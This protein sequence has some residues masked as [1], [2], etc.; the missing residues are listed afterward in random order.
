LGEKVANYYINFEFTDGIFAYTEILVSTGMVFEG[1][2]IHAG[3]GIYRAAL[4]DGKEA[5]GIEYV[6]SDGVH[7]DIKREEIC[8]YTEQYLTHG[9]YDEHRHFYDCLKKGVNPNSGA[10][11]ALQSVRVCEALKNREGFVV[12]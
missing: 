3:E 10:D 2:E 8:P 4:Q 5:G 11:T 12:F 9:F 6:D 1:C 7:I